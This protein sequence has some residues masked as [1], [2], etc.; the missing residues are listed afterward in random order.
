[1][2]SFA[3]QLYQECNFCHSGLLL[4]ARCFPTFSPTAYNLLNDNHYLLND[5]AS[6]A[7]TSISKA[8]VS[9]TYQ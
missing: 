8:Q 5:L 1:M 7:V 4:H 2:L 3:K 9:S 6:Q